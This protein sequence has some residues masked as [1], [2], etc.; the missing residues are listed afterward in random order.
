MDSSLLFGIALAAYGLSGL[1]YLFKKPGPGRLIMIIGLIVQTIGLSIRAV[2][3]GH[4][5]FTNLYES[6]LFFSWS[7]VVVGLY[8][9]RRYKTKIAGPIVVPMA[10]LATGYALLLSPQSKGITPLM[11]ALQSHWLEIHVITCFLAYA[12][13]ALA[14]GAGIIYLIKER[15]QKTQEKTLTLLDELSYKT[16]ALGVIFLTLGIITG[17][18]W[19]NYAWGS[20][21]SWDPKE[22]WALITWLIYMIYLHLRLRANFSGRRSAW[23]AV[24]GFVAVI[25][26]YLGVNL[27]LSGLHSYA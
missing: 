25:F 8:V 15:N 13:F 26:T 10:F 12:A 17:A 14:F 21:W 1:L 27:L 22:T 4:A 6:M 23:L 16:I 2:K 19:A 9:E 3:A 20:Y 5:P 18:I 24:I 11:P 7:M